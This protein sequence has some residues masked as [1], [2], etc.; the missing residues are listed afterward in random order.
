MHSRTRGIV[1]RP[2]SQR[3]AT[4]MLVAAACLLSSPGPVHGSDAPAQIP[5]V[6]AGREIDPAVQRA[7]AEHF[8][9]VLVFHRDEKYF[10]TTPLFPLALDGDA[11]AFA[12]D[13]ASSDRL[14]SAADRRDRYEELSL[15]DKAQLAQVFYRAYHAD[16]GGA[17]FVIVEYWLYYVHNTYRVRGNL[18]PLWVDGSHPN[19][20][21]HIHLVLRRADDGRL[22]PF[23]VYGTAHN[24]TMPANRHRYREEP[25]DVRGR[26]LVELGSHALAPDINGDG[27]YTPGEDG[28]S[29]YKVLWGIRDRGITWARYRAGYMDARGADNSIVLRLSGTG[30]TPA[31]AGARG[32]GLHEDGFDD[33]SAEGSLAY[34]L[35]PVEELRA[36]F[37]A[38]DL[39]TQQRRAIFETPRHWFRRMFGGDTGSSNKLLVPP[40]QVER[41][42]SV[43]IDGFSSTERGLLF[44]THINMADQGLLVGARY[45]YFLGGRFV[46]DLLAEA[47]AV[48]SR[49]K[50]Y[51]SGQVMVTYPLD[52]TT[53][54]MAGKAL[55]VTPFAFGRQQWDW[56]AGLEFSLGR[57]RIYGGS[58]SPG[59]LTGGSKEVRLVYL[60]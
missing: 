16:R 42:T 27:L 36:A 2:R 15:R 30:A 19:D 53:T 22:V 31:D 46:P 21:E 45:A 24:G 50:R 59:P 57:M 60:F 26:F 41:R 10:P 7:L 12:I 25:Q 11:Q 20:L 56:V 34:R 28:S 5:P 29:G 32:A 14:G 3:L 54:I 17:T 55:V 43:G 35:V 8:A 33:A 47:D 48:V 18:L 1:P 52:G 58:R 44:G 13:A 6:E 23:E 49:R 38:L 40:Q 51:F 37:A 9:P 4:A 39:N